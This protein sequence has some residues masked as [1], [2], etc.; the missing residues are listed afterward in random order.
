M[1]MAFGS[2]NEFMIFPII[3][4]V[5]KEIKNLILRGELSTEAL[6]NAGGGG[7]RNIVLHSDNSNK[8][9]VYDGNL[10]MRLESNDFDLTLE[11]N[12]TDKPNM[13]TG[14][15]IK[16]GED[17]W[18]I[19]NLIRENNKL[20]NVKIS[21]VVREPVSEGVPNP[22][23]M[24][25]SDFIEYVKNKKVWQYYKLILDDESSTPEDKDYAQT[26]IYWLANRNQEL[27][28]MYGIP[29]ERDMSYEELMEFMLNPL[30]MEVFDFIKYCLNGRIWFSETATQEEKDDAHQA[31]VNLRAK[32]FIS[33]EDAGAF[34]YDELKDYLPNPLGMHSN[35]FITYVENRQEIAGLDPTDPIQQAQIDQIQSENDAL[36]AKY[37]ITDDYSLGQLESYLTQNDTNYQENVL[38]KILI[39]LI[40]DK[41]GK[42]EGV[43]S[44]TQ[45]GD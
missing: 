13:L 6:E 42:L 15:V 16:Y 7:N 40:Y 8:K 44:E 23:G 37:Y 25:G 36:L 26:R 32:Y 28:N 43:K 33:E 2:T 3:E 11:K 41:D 27:R 9:I 17:L 18:Q 5:R 14:V 31:N 1:V 38:L 4:I 30:G 24:G 20:T 45:E 29:L 19:I 22:Y 12:D 35:D 39:S 10:L 34:K 21:I